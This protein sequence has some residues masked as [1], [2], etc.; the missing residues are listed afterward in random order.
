G[1]AAELD[2]QL[3]GAIR[4]GI[5]QI[6]VKL[7]ESGIAKHGLRLGSHVSG[8]AV[9]ISRLDH[10]RLPA[11]VG[12]E[13]DVRRIYLQRGERWPLSLRQVGKPNDAQDGKNESHGKS[14][15]PGKQK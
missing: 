12:L 6:L 9:G 8:D 15:L 11:A 3:G 7:G 13:F 4:L 1:S 5:E 2:F 14:L 10:E